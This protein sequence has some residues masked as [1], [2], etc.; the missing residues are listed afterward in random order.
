MIPRPTD[1]LRI[2]LMKNIHPLN[3]VETPNSP[4]VNPPHDSGSDK[5]GFFQDANSDHYPD[6]GHVTT[7]DTVKKKK[8]KKF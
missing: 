8:K 7:G 1:E 3:P 2:E 4:D 5:Y 6:I